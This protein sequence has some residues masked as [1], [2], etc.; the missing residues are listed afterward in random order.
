VAEH[1]IEKRV[2]CVDDD[3]AGG[4]GGDGV[5]ELAAELEREL[6]CLISFQLTIDPSVGAIRPRVG[7]PTCWR[8]SWSRCC[9]LPVT[10]IV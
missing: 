8:I 1:Q 3:G 6:G 9:C 10:G 7:G 4:L 2:R 5:D